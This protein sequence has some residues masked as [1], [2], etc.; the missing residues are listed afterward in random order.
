MRLVDAGDIVDCCAPSSEAGT[1]MWPLAFANS[2]N[3]AAY[4]YTN[5]L[6]TAEPFC[7][8]VKTADTHTVPTP[9]QELLLSALNKLGHGL[10]FIEVTNMWN[11]MKVA[12]WHVLLSVPV[13]TVFSYG[14]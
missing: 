1:G 12:V 10:L 2:C 14:S 11:A 6:W 3:L 13:S 4:I 5:D 9:D 7:T 8:R